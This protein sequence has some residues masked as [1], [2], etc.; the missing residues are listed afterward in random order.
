MSR[1]KGRS[2]II[3]GMNYNDFELVDFPLTGITTLSDCVVYIFC[4]LA[5]GAEVPFYVGESG[6][7]PGRMNDYR[8]ACFGATT[9][10]RVGEAVKYFINLNYRIVVKYK[11]SAAD[12]AA[13]RKEERAVIA[14]LQEEGFRL[15]NS[16]RGYDYRSADETGERSALQGFCKTLVP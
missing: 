1:N 3:A 2:G 10:F 8:L 9:D 15:L 12:E 4:F 11:Q 6:R 5:K 7:F 16:F 13:R 14:S